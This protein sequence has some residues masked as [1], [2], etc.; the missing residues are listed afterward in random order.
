VAVTIK[1]RKE[2]GV[3]AGLFL[4]LRGAHPYLISQSKIGIWNAGSHDVGLI[5]ST[6]APLLGIGLQKQS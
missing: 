3:S 2:K 6:K 4:F 5:H 1:T